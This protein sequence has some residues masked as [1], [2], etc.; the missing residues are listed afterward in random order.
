MYPAI[1]ISRLKSGQR[2]RSPATTSFASSGGVA[3][4]NLRFSTGV[5]R[6]GF[7]EL[8]LGV[9]ILVVLQIIGFSQFRYNTIFT[10]PKIVNVQDS[11]KEEYN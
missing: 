7:F 5:R 6:G 4:E 1:E 10:V 9:V 8:K 11:S 2:L 3:W